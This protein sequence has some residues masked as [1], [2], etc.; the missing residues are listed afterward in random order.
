MADITESFKLKTNPF[1]LTPTTN[2]DEL[3][4]AGFKDMKDKFEKRIQRSIRIPNSTLV[5]NWGEYGSGKTHAARYFNKKD[6]LEELAKNVERVIPYSMVISL[7]KGKEPIF[8]L[9]TSV[10]DKLNIE[11]IR[12]LFSDILPSVGE[13]IALISS[14][15]HIQN[16]LKGIFNSEIDHLDIKKYLYGNMSVSDLKSLNRHGILRMLRDDTDYSSLIAGLFSSLTFDKKKFSC[17]ILWI[18]EFEDIAVLN[19][20]SIDKTNNFIREILDNVPNNLLLFLNLTQS[21]LISVEDLG[22]YIYDSVRSRIKERI[23]FDLPSQMVFKDYLVELLTL[24]RDSAADSKYFPFEE[25]VIDEIIR[26]QGNV[27]L[28]QFNE[29]LSL[30]LELSDMDNKCPIDMDVYNEYKDDIIWQKD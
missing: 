8:S 29:S 4:W 30:L 19:N 23:S 1:R 14:N 12:K 25:N 21:A 24:F 11:E 22:Q 27:S 7:P 5:L 16:V 13:Y 9:Y 28:R 10:I 2:P 3:E 17:I 6:V 26:T 18:D 15:I 20:T